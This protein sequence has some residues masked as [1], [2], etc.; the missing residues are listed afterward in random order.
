MTG[1]DATR[2]LAMSPVTIPQCSFEEAFRV[3]SEAGFGGIGLRYNRL[4][5]YL[6]TGKSIR[7]VRGLMKRYG[8]RITEAAFLAE[9]QFQGGLPL[10]CKR[11]RTGAAEENAAILGQELTRFF[12]RCEE[13]EC[14]NV[15]VVPSLRQVGDLAIAAQEFGTLCDLAKPH[16][17]RLCL[18]FMGTA[19]QIKDLATAQQMVA[20]AG[21]SNGGL[22]IDTFL[23]HQGGSTLDDLENVPMEYVFNVQLADAKPLPVE[24]LNMLADRLFPG[25][26]VAP[27]EEIV[28]VLTRRGYQGWWTVEL[29]NPEYAEADPYV[30]A[31]TS[32]AMAAGIVDRTPSQAT[33]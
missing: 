1:N 4:E 14:E 22:V 13:L 20:L 10:I 17:L 31:E 28:S 16:G 19:P 33:V 25:T 5:E 30:V 26:G 24:Q 3:T 8:L 29:F 15:T 21:R 12:A 18:E 7:D 23:F 27:V 32:Y 6:A 11:E 2:R 9:W